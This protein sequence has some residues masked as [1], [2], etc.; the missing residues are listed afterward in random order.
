MIQILYQD[1]LLNGKNEI[2]MNYII[3]IIILIIQYHRIQV[4]SKSHMRTS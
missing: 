3:Y 1:H 4:Y 2:Q